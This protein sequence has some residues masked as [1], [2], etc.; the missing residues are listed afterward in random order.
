MLGDDVCP[1]G[2]S[3]SGPRL[4]VVVPAFNAERYLAQALESV[5]AEAAALGSGQ[6]CE[7][8]VVD[9]ASSDG[10]LSVAAA[11][12]GRGV[13]SLSRPLQGGP[14]AARNSGVAAAQGELLAFLDAD[15][16]WPA[17]RLALL[18]S[19]LGKARAPAIAFGHARQFACPLMD[20]DTRR[21]LRIPAEA[22]PG[23]CTGA[24]LLRRE[25]HLRV[26]RFTETLRVGEFIEWF[27][28]AHDLGFAIAL[29][30][31]IVLERRIHGA[32][33]TVRHR[34]DYGDYTQ[35]LKRVL[36]R[37]RGGAAQ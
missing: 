35:A 5:L 6:G 19:A 7:V 36:D 12:A 27:G 17:G 3:V 28:R 13:R 14:G 20:A 37:R 16:L 11:F 2:R 9:D 23:Y 25:D 22:T 21:R 4:S 30:P 26:G 24:M 32:N 10:T 33:Q 34:A 29:I 8:I 1:E 15:D 31:E 18:L